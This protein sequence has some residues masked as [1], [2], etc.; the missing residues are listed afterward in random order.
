LPILYTQGFSPHPVVSFGP[1]LP[2]GVTSRAEYLDLPLEGYDNDL[3][4]DLNRVLPEGLFGLEF[5][6]L[7][8]TAP[9]LGRS[10]NLA[11]Y[12]VHSSN[13]IDPGH[14]DGVQGVYQLERTGPETF[15]LWLKFAPGIRLFPTLKSILGAKPQVLKVERQEVY[16]LKDGVLRNPLE[17]L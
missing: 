4:Q 15:L 8:T 12:W 1:P 11:E 16:S 17:E 3:V 14:I 10:V 5:R 2:V 6:R 9:S 13:G 7:P